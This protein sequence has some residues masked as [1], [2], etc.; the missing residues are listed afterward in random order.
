MASFDK[1][2]VG[3]TDN[4]YCN[5]GV[6][7]ANNGGDMD[8]ALSYIRKRTKGE[9]RDFWQVRKEAEVLAKISKY[10]KAIEIAE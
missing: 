5:A 1:T 3:P 10:K 4:D 9:K 6:Y 2:L 7:M 8:R